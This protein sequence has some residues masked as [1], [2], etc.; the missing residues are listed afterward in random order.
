MIAEDV[1]KIIE[2]DYTKVDINN[3]QPGDVIVFSGSSE[4]EKNH[5]SMVIDF[6]E[7]YDSK[8]PK[9]LEERINVIGNNGPQKG[10]KI[11]CL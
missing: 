2:D 9:T 1:T 6:I 8:N 4:G 11:H 7:A 10:I 3:A 5:H